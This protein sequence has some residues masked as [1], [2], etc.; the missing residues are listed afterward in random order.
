MHITIIWVENQPGART[1]MP[2]VTEVRYAKAKAHLQMRTPRTRVIS[3]PAVYFSAHA[4]KICIDEEPAFGQKETETL[5]DREPR[6]G[7]RT[8]RDSAKWSNRLLVNL[9]SYGEHT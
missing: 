1:S 5:N 7:N 8:C 2:V 4:G 9:P 6:I 3:V